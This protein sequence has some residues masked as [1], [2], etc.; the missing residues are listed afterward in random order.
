MVG[1]GELIEL[2]KIYQELDKDAVAA[3]IRTIGFAKR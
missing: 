1:H 3:G 2:L